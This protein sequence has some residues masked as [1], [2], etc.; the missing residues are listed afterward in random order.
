MQHPRPHLDARVGVAR[1]LERDAGSRGTLL[2]LGR[3][4]VEHR[5]H[6]RRAQR[7]DAGA[8]LELAEE[9]HLVDQL[10]DLLDL[11]ASL[12]DEVGDVL[13]GQQRELEQREQTGE[14]R[15]ELVRDR[16]REARAQ[17]LVGRHVADPREV[18]E[19]LV[20]TVDDVG[21]DERVRAVEQLRREAAHPRG[22]PRATGGHGGSRRA[23][24]P[25]ASTHDHGLAALLEQHPA[26]FGVRLHV[27]L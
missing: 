10:A 22:R 5:Q 1:H 19:P 8:R 2:E 14:R 16:R 21:D 7:D 13:A 25:S 12:V 27:R 9:E 24:I 6:R 20:A 3:D 11:A 15:P 26:S 4:V 17:L 23:P 18:D